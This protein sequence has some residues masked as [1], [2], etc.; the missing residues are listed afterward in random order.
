MEVLDEYRIYGASV[1][2]G[3][4]NNANDAQ[5]TAKDVS[6]DNKSVNG[7]LVHLLNLILCHAI[8]YT[9]RSMNVLSLVNIKSSDLDMVEN[10]F[11]IIKVNIFEID[12]FL[13]I[14]IILYE[15]L[16]R[17]YSYILRIL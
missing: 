6:S 17:C 4:T 5:K 11:N 15:K 8:V 12:A 10:F 7:C 13:I 1:Y 3:T 16:L 2:S 14:F 9:R